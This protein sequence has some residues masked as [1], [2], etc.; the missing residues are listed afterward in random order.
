MLHLYYLRMDIELA[1]MEWIEWLPYVSKERRERVARFHIL[2][3]AQR[4]LFGELL[5][6]YA[7]CDNT[8]RENNELK[9][10]QNRFGKPMLK[11]EEDKSEIHFNLSHSGRWIVCAV[12][13]TP[14]GIDVEEMK[15]MSL[16]IARSFFSKDE[17]E[18]LLREPEI[19]RQE[20]FFALWTMKESFIKADGRGLSLS[21][22]QFTIDVSRGRVYYQQKWLNRQI[23]HSQL[24]EEHMLAVCAFSK[25]QM[26]TRYLTLSEFITMVANRL[27]SIE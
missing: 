5:T 14:I 25:S 15:P 27:N 20:Y 23:W 4:S 10:I 24:D 9:F 7:L 3:D 11:R 13:Y 18:A 12:D 6:R 17:Y 2:K 26:L 1:S 21:L 22:D 16:Q 8:G 19:S